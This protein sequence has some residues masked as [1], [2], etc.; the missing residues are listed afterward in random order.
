MRQGSWVQGSH[1]TPAKCHNSV[2]VLKSHSPRKGTAL[3]RA[4]STGGTFQVCNTSSY[5]DCRQDR[6][7][8]SR[9]HLLKWFASEQFK[10]S[11]TCSHQCPPKHGAFVST[12]NLALVNW[13]VFPLCSA[14]HCKNRKD[15]L[16]PNT[17]FGNEWSWDNVNSLA[18]AEENS[19]ISQP[20]LVPPPWSPSQGLSMHK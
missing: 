9:K 15:E 2:F 18:R 20:S 7:Y 16:N 13:N 12:S 3:M 5:S 4:K 17:V 14:S 8:W 19:G 10:Q 1:P 6:L 11:P